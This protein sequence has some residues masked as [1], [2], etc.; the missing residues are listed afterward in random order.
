MAPSNV[1]RA[2]R[3]RLRW[4]HC[5]PA[6]SAKSNVCR[7][8]RLIFCSLKKKG[9]YLIVHVVHARSTV[10]V[11]FMYITNLIKK[12]TRVRLYVC[13]ICI[14]MNIELAMLKIFSSNHTKILFLFIFDKCIIVR[15]RIR[16]YWITLNYTTLL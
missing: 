2:L 5:L 6:K 13:I 7:A 16:D 4:L 1:C 14:Y 15:H 8:S 10:S 12:K 11:K 3:D 9:A